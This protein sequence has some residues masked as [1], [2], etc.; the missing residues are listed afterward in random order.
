MNIFQL[1]YETIWRVHSCYFFCIAEF[2]SMLTADFSMSIH[3]A[4]LILRNLSNL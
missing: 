1:D 4:S 3:H 2:L